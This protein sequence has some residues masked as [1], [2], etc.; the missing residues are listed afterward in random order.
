M[1][2]FFASVEL[3]HYPALSGQPVV[4]G[5]RHQNPEAGTAFLR[6]R[7]YIGRGVVTTST[8]E[9]RALGVHSGMALMAAARRA[10]EAILLPPR[11]AAYRLASQRFKAAVA[12]LGLAIED[13]GIDEIYVDLTDHAGARWWAAARLRAAVYD[14][15]G[16]S[17]SIGIAANKLLA[18][19][20]SELDKPHGLTILETGDLATRLWPLPVGRIP[21]IGPKSVARL[22]TLGVSTIG[23][24]AHAPRAVLI[25][26]FGARGAQA[27]QDAAWGIDDRPLITVATRQSLSRETTFAHDLDI[28]ADRATL[29]TT[30]TTLCRQIGDDLTHQGLGGRTIGVKLRDADFHTQTRAITLRGPT[31]DVATIHA[32]ACACLHRAPLA[33]RLRL[34]GVRVAGLTRTDG[35][36]DRAGTCQRPLPF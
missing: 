12:T 7:H 10:P 29:T 27:L 17:C 32:A 26:T 35:S 1:D 36:T 33:P 22:A 18:K 14:A 11:F 4:V 3:L 2:A 30:L 6:L 28:V 16:L 9:A 24:L 20:A 8:Y 34:L 15:T 13:H 25:A 5:G 21:G 23:A 19:L 31:R